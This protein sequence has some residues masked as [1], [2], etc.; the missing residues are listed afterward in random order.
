MV[1]LKTGYS[2]ISIRAGDMSPLQT[3]E[4]AGSTVRN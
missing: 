4:I 1:I 2:G 3:S